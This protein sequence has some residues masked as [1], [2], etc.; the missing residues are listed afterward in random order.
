MY[1]YLRCVGFSFFSTSQE[2]VRG[3]SRISCQPIYLGYTESDSYLVK[4]DSRVWKIL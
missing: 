4:E 2:I 1:G 3:V